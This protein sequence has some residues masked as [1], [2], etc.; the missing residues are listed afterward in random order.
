M[1]IPL[2]TPLWLDTTAPPAPGQRHAPWQ[3]L[4][5]AQ[6]TGPGRVWVLL[7]REIAVK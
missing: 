6:D 3:R 1:V 2:S 7:P 5:V 4:V